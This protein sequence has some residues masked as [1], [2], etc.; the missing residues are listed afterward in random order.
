MKANT[1]LAISPLRG[2]KTARNPILQEDVHL[3]PSKSSKGRP[4]HMPESHLA[5]EKPRGLAKGQFS[6]LLQ[7]SFFV[8]RDPELPYKPWRKQVITLKP[9]DTSPPLSV[10]PAHSTP[11]RRNPS[12]QDSAEFTTAPRPVSPHWT[13][14]HQMEAENNKRHLLPADLGRRTPPSINRTESRIFAALEDTVQREV[15]P[16]GRKSVPVR[17]S[18]AADLLR[19][20][21]ALPY[22]EKSLSPK[23]QEVPFKQVESWK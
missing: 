12:L 16:V 19:Y 4:Q 22:R 17:Q 7:G 18:G 2:S 23:P 13:P 6:E 8:G 14:S 3:S 20:R 9:R 1:R 11:P 15:S 21:F 5:S 10:T